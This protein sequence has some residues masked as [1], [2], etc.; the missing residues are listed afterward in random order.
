MQIKILLTIV[1]S[2]I[3]FNGHSE[4]SPISGHISKLNERE[5]CPYLC[6][7][8]CISELNSVLVFQESSTY[9][10]F[11]YN[12]SKQI[13]NLKVCS[14]PILD[15]AFSDMFQEIQ[16]AHYLVSDDYHPFYYKLT[17]V[18]NCIETIVTSSNRCIINNENLCSHIDNLKSFLIN[19]WMISFYSH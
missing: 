19:L 7:E 12:N 15:W 8:F 16:D 9:S 4:L 11:I 14:A 5:N 2:F 3:Y 1:F 17:F 6:Y 10:I 13:D 18:D